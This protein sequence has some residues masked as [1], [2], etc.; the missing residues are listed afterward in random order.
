MRIVQNVL[1]ALTTFAYLGDVG[2]AFDLKQ[3][4]IQEVATR[5]NFFKSASV[6]AAATLLSPAKSGAFDVG[7][8]IK[9]GDESIMSQKG[10]W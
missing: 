7:G 5:R 4:K 1:F 2:S 8:K 6:V 9:Y 10:R 3:V